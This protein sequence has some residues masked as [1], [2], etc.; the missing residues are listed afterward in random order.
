M[1]LK[2]PLR[3]SSEVQGWHGMHAEDRNYRDGVFFGDN[4]SD[5]GKR[6][7]VIIVVA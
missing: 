7:L 4:F 2:M 1:N 3:F 5:R 6:R